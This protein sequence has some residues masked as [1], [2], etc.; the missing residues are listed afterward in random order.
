MLKRFKLEDMIP[1]IAE[2]IKAGNRF[3]LYPRG[4][5]MLP[6]IYEDQTAVSLVKAENVKENDVVLYQRKNGQYVL[7]R[8]VKINGN[9]YIMC[10][11][12]QFV[13]EKG[14]TRDM[15]IAKIDGYYPGEDFVSVDDSAYIKYVRSL[16]C[17]R[18]NKKL[19]YYFR[20][21]KT[22]IMKP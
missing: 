15:I 10:G 21:I 19:K 14:I 20:R 5:S 7:H 13:L 22:K 6:M 4:T 9:E 2:T 17:R 12:N 18:F 16:P 11:D 8:C 3:K 1:V